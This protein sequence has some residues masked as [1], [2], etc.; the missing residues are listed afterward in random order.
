MW[1]QWLQVTLGL[2]GI[3]FYGKRKLL[4]GELKE[5][6][7]E[8]KNYDEINKILEESETSFGTETNKGTKIFESKV[9]YK[10][11]QFKKFQRSYLTVT[12]L[13][14]FS[15]WLQGPYSYALYSSYSYSQGAIP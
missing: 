4:S 11:V 13:A 10:D 2:L 12:I 8:L 5:D 7:L 14:M 1:L 3:S 6:E 15:D 9:T